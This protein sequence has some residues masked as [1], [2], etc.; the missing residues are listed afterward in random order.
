VL[1]SL[2][3]APA[4]DP[5]FV[6]AGGPG[7]SAV[8]SLPHMRIAAK[9]RERRHVVAVDQR[10]TGGSNPLPCAAK[11]LDSPGAVVGGLF[12][13]DRIRACRVELEKRADLTQ[14]TTTS[15]VDDVD[16]VRAAL[17]F[18]HINVYG[19]SYGTESAMVYLRRH[20]DRVRAVALKAVKPVQQK[21]PLLL[22][23]TIQASI[24]RFLAGDPQLTRDFHAVVA[25]L[26]KAPARFQL[27]GQPASISTGTFL[28]GMRLLLYYPRQV[29]QLPGMLREAARGNWTPFATAH[30]NTVRGGEPRIYRGM[31]FSV[32][33]AEDVAATTDAE[34]AR[35]TAGTWL[36]DFQVQ[37]YRE[38][39]KLWPRGVAPA[40]FFD[41]VRSSKP[42]LLIAGENDPATPVES[43]RLVAQT[44]PNSRV[45]A[46]QGGTHMTGSPCLD[47]MVARFIDTG[48]ASGLPSCPE[49]RPAQH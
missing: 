34:V 30:L 47:D 1:P 44:L 7:E 21:L 31:H 6:F 23:R 15:F 42:V 10:G 37:H 27:Q 3:A 2:A 26:A 38:A 40:G 33:C 4:A 20:E 12:D 22:S 14:Y 48:T 46:I 9:L 16:E 36:G 19:G 32:L 43:A 45:V 8:D 5:V 41:P 35:E 18:P 49:A 11:N 28:S 25:R 24:E 39:C 17:G 29:E 13:L